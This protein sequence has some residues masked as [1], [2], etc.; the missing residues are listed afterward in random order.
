MGHHR[1]RNNEEIHFFKTKTEHSSAVTHT[2]LLEFPYP[3]PPVSLFF[4]PSK[5]LSPPHPLSG[6]LV[7]FGQR[8]E[9]PQVMDMVGEVMDMVREVMGMV[10]EVMGMVREMMNMV[11]EVSD[12]V[13]EVIDMIGEGAMYLSLCILYLL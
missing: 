6:K 4:I 5:D 3:P 1:I 2:L 12:M 8:G 10:R 7:L 9:S 11:R 13:G